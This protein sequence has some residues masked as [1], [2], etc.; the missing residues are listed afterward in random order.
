MYADT[1]ISEMNLT[2]LI[3]HTFIVKVLNTWH[4]PSPPLDFLLN[5]VMGVSHKLDC[6]F[7]KRLKLETPNKN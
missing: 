2:R 1:S 7:N 4:L 5:A 3:D 6:I